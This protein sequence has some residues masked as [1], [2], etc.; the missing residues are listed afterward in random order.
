MTSIQ[1][2]SYIL[3][4]ENKLLRVS[5]LS[6]FCQ[7]LTTPAFFLGASASEE[8]IKVAEIVCSTLQIEIASLKE[9]L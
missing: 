2:G 9:A 6:N 4:A 7:V 8:S 1:N 3:L 5:L